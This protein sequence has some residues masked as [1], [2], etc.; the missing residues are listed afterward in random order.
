MVDSLDQVTF[1]QMNNLNSS[2]SVLLSLPSYHLQD[3]EDA[4]ENLIVN[5]VLIY[6]WYLESFVS[7]RKLFTTNIRFLAAVI[8]Y[9]EGIF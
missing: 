9:S 2:G 1:F 4:R 6:G 3:Y 5:L 8:K 7:V